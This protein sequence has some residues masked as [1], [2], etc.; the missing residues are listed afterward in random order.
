MSEFPRRISDHTYDDFDELLR[1]LRSLGQSGSVE[2]PGQWFP[3][4]RFQRSSDADKVIL[5]RAASVLIRD[6]THPGVLFLCTNMAAWNYELWHPAV[7][8]RLEQGPSIL[9]DHPLGRGTLL[10]VVADTLC[11][12]RMNDATLLRARALMFEHAPLASRMY[13][14]VNR[15][16]QKELELVLSTY[17]QTDNF[18]VGV[19]RLATARLVRM[20]SDQGDEN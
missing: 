19:V 18:N 8:D 10:K 16:N 11:S 20:R 6:A 5:G 1:R 3:V 13:F 12:G 9:G 2:N 17:T 7:M 15:G 4:D 14:M